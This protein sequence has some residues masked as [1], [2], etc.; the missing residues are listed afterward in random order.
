MPDPFAI[1]SSAA[2]QLQERTGV[3]RHDLFVVL[4]SGWAT[5][6]DLLPAGVDVPVTDLP[7]FEAPSV[8]GH[9]GVLRSL[10]VGPSR[11]LLSRG[12][13]HLYEGHPPAT[14]VH[15]VRTAAAAG[16]R[17]AV[18]TNAAGMIDPAGVVGSAV[19]ISDQ[20]NMTGASPL[21]GAEF[22]DLTDLYS[23]RLR[24]VVHDVAPEVPDGVYVGTHGPEFESPAE[25]RA[26]RTMGADLVGMSTVLESIAAR[27]LGME[28][29]GLAMVTN[30]AA[31]VGGAAVDPHHV[32]AVAESAAPAAGELLVRILERLTRE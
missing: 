2:R 31:G 29:A 1:A 14:V 11:V 22:V 12:R 24:A 27:H 7:G 3:E 19:L 30:M 18:F 5:A 21:V 26:Y 25:I 17:V 32:W 9:A 13:V 10:V 6:A 16:C 20:I 23:E 28:V 8:M 15:A 4:G